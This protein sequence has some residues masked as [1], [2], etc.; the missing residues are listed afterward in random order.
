MSALTDF[1]LDPVSERFFGEDC[2][3]EAPAPALSR[4]D[5]RA[6]RATFT[7]LG[8]FG[9]ALLAFVIYARV[10]M[11]L[12]AELDGGRSLPVLPQATSETQP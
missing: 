7:M 5:L 6:M 4:G 12:P 8:V 11:P 3:D 10:I 1:Q 9:L 2:A